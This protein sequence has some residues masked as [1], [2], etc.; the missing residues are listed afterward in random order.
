MIKNLSYRN[1][2][3]SLDLLYSGFADSD[4]GF[5]FKINFFIKT[6]H[7]NILIQ[8]LSRTSSSE[9]GFVTE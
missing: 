8:I 2:A 7:K 5:S 9:T 1:R 6:F 3:R 4:A